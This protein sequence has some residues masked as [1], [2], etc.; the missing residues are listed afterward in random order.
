VVE[1]ITGEFFRQTT[2]ESLADVVRRFDPSRY[3]PAAC[4]ANA[5]RFDTGVFKEKWAAFVGQHMA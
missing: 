1:G 2:P 3:D 5:Q 4:V